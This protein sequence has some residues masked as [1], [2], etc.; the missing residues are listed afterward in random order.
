MA[1]SLV[2]AIKHGC[3]APF[4]ILFSVELSLK[5]FHSY[6]LKKSSRNFTFAIHF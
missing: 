1:L 5:V 6:K 4:I 3:D 2:A